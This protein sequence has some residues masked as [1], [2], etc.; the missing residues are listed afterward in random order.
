MAPRELIQVS[1]ENRRRLEAVVQDGNAKQKHVW[2]AQ[3]ILESADGHGTMEIMRRV[4]VSNP[5]VWRWQAR[6]AQQGVGGLFLNA[7]RPPGKAP[8]PAS[9]VREVVELTHSPPP[10]RATHWTLRAMA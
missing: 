10:G 6:Y 3:I 1:A 8:V 5:T 9:K 2:R 4:G 7:T